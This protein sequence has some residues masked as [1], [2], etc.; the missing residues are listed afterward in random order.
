MKINFSVLLVAISIAANCA[1]ASPLATNDVYKI[2]APEVKKIFGD[3]RQDTFINDGLVREAILEF[4][5]SPDEPHELFSGVTMMTGC[6]PQ[7]CDEK[8]AVVVDGQM[9]QLLAAAILHFHCRE[10]LLAD[11]LST[12]LPGNKCDTEGTLEIFVIRRSRVLANL[13]HELDYVR[14]LEAW[15]KEKQ[16]KNEVIHIKKVPSP[17]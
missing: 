8:G 16:F 13:K 1:Y 15:G 3:D 6:R 14:E 17:R 5:G 10:T 2:T 12:Q 9:K 11:Q 7:S 4:I